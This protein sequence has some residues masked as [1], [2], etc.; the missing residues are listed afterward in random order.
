MPSGSFSGTTVQTTSSGTATFTNLRI[1]SAGSLSIQAT[2]TDMVSVTS[3]QTT[4]TNYAYQI[5]LSS[6]NL[7][8]TVNFL[9]TLSIT[10][11]GED[12][13][14]FKGSCAITL[15]GSNLAGALTGSTSTGQ[16]SLQP[17]F[18]TTGSKTITA[19]CPASGS[20]PSVSGQL[21]FTVLVQVLKITSFTAVTFT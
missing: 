10:I 12:L 6:T 15:T 5:T 9:F 3:I 16:L 4:I 21:S 18:T 2:C 7:S 11:K 13:A 8:P 17:Y 1:L 20:S 19:T 14:L